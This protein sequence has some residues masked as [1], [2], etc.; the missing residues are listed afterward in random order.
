[1]GFIA[2]AWARIPKPLQTTL[3]GLVTAGSSVWG[4]SEYISSKPEVVTPISAG[5]QQLIDTGHIDRK[6][7][8]QAINRAI[9]E[10]FNAKG[11]CKDPVVAEKDIAETVETA[12]DCG[13]ASTPKP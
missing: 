4:T 3:I 6:E 11:F 12:R 7:L 8:K 1:M 9:E 13:T 5:R 2:D 10:T